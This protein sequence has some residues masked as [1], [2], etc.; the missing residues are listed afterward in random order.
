MYE[1]KLNFPIAPDKTFYQNSPCERSFFHMNYSNPFSV[2]WDNFLLLY[3]FRCIFKMPWMLIWSIQQKQT[4]LIIISYSIVSRS[5]LMI[6]MKN[7]GP[8]AYANDWS[9][10]WAKTNYSL[11]I[12]SLRPFSALFNIKDPHNQFEMEKIFVH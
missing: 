7:Y 12:K 9:S 8:K 1:T 3:L 5:N 6:S 2:Y 4:H 11:S 10:D